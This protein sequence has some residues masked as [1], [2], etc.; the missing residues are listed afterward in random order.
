MASMP[1]M[2]DEKSKGL[3]DADQMVMALFSES[4]PNGSPGSNRADSARP[5]KTP[6]D[7]LAEELADSRKPGLM[8]KFRFGRRF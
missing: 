8:D 2:L 5:L 3:S 4:G 7:R 6:D 1:K